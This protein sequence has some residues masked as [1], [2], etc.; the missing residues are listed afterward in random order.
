MA[1]PHRVKS[2]QGRPHYAQ[3]RSSRMKTLTV[4]V[5]DVKLT[6]AQVYRATLRRYAIEQ[7]EKGY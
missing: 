2:W 1:C 7:W 5:G 6:I 3:K 4:P